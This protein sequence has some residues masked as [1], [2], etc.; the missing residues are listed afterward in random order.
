MTSDEAAQQMLDDP[1]FFFHWYPLRVWG[2]AY[3]FN[4][5]A[6]N[7]R[8]YRVGRH[9][10]TDQ[11]DIAR[12]KLGH[13]GA[14]RPGKIFRKNISSFRMAP[15]GQFGVG[16]DEESAVVNTC[17]VPMVNFNSDIYGGLNLHANVGAMHPYHVT[18]AG[19]YMTTG[20]LSGCTFV[21][22]EVANDLHCIHVQPSG[23]L[24]GHGGN[25]SG[26][27]LQN[28]IDANAHFNGVG[29]AVNTFGRNQYGGLNA[30]VVGVLHHGGW[31]L[32]AQSSGDVFQTIHSAWRLH[33]LPLV[34][35]R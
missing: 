17:C 15:D 2:G 13:H 30:T 18:A 8:P 33:P 1:D 14:T 24:P 12:G 10:P 20:Q 16:F 11:N 32:Y 6:V 29:G 21:W 7:L 27:N 26:V 3:P 22:I 28:H 31:R 5:D 23:N 9:Q 4:A 34:Q 19:D 35:L 25:I